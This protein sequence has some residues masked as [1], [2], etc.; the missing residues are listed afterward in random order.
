MKNNESNLFFKELEIFK[1]IKIIVLISIIIY[2]KL[3][4]N[5]SHIPIDKISVIIPTYNRGYLILKSVKSVLNQTYPNIE[6]LIVDDGS[7]DD[8]ENLINNLNND[9]IKYIKIKKN[10]GGSYA[11]NI[12]IMKAS[13]KYISF[14]DSDDNYHY[15]KLEKQYNNL[16]KKKSDFDFCKIC[17]HINDKIKMVFPTVEQEKNIKNEKYENELCNGNYISTQS[18]LVKKAIIRKYL[19]DIKFPRLQD[20]DLVLRMI[21][22]LKVSYTDEILVDLYRE[23]DSIGNSQ[24]KYNESLNLLLNKKY[25]IKCNIETIYNIFKKNQQ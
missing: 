8:T 20:Y 5:S 24:K 15:D 10:N 6:V 19:F 21:P 13:G 18:I 3:K 22:N 17:L 23:K 1:I 7:T 25:D 9:K 14:Q 4:I 11:R 16:I 12:G 2:F